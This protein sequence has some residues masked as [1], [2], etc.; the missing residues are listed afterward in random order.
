M[1]TDA[2]GPRQE[3]EVKLAAADLDAVRERLRSLAA[4]LRNARH[5]EINDLYDDSERKLSGGGKTLRLRRAGDRSV[6]TYK[7]RA[8]FQNGVKTREEREVEVSDPDEAEAILAGIGLSKRFRYE[9]RREEWN[10]ES[11]VVALDETPIGRFVE[12]E[13]DPIAI[14]RVVVELGL[15]F[16][17]ALPYSYS[18]LYQ[19]ARKENPDLPAD[20]VWAVEP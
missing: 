16:A 12:V 11:T 9:K 4:V 1:R 17:Q 19:R 3:I 18:E 6:L 15:D 14:R 13:G 20:M 7:G 5:E 10:L 8:H 2:S